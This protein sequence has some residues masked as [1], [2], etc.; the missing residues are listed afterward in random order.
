MKKNQTRE[1]IDE[2]KEIILDYL[3]YR[4]VMNFA[5]I[6]LIFDLF[7]IDWQGDQIIGKTK[8]NIVFWQGWNKETTKAF[9][10]LFNDHKIFIIP[11][12]KSSSGL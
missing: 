2:I 5:E 6:E 8:Q 12:K 1:K 11:T 3:S 4:H 10:E 7:G 9:Y